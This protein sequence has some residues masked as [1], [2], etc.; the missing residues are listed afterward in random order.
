MWAERAVL[1][2]GESFGM[3]LAAAEGSRHVLAARQLVA[4]MYA[5]VD[6]R[7]ERFVSA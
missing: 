3:I 4:T 5:S 2:P 6:G 1:L 7:M